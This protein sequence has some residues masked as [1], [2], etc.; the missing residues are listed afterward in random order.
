MIDMDIF[1]DEDLVCLPFGVSG[2][3]IPVKYRKR[4]TTEPTVVRL[5]GPP[6]VMMVHDIKLINP[7]SNVRSKGIINFRKFSTTFVDGKNEGDKCPYR[8]FN[9]R[10]GRKVYFFNAIIREEDIYKESNGK[11]RR[12][13]TTND[14]DIKTPVRVIELTA[15][16][17][18][19]LKG[20]IKGAKLDKEKIHADIGI[21]WKKS[22][23]GNGNGHV[24]IGFTLVNTSKTK[25]KELYYPRWDLDSIKAETKKEAKRNIEIMRRY[26][27]KDWSESKD[28][29]WFDT[30]MYFAEYKPENHSPQF[31]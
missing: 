15:G 1:S 24:Q 21:Y 12:F 27:P 23:N 7:T 16:Q 10:A 9:G 30:E 22:E 18:K 20:I 14:G 6:K 26:L 31:A 11:K 19:T 28:R 25:M 3:K 13:I 8:R 29:Q 4:F 5:F 2:R 17:Y